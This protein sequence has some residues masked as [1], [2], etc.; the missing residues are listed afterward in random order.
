MEIEYGTSLIYKMIHSGRKPTALM[1]EVVIESEVKQDL[2]DGVVSKS[3][4]PSTRV[5]SHRRGSRHFIP[6]VNPNL[7]AFV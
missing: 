6:G 2:T 3:V 1:D 7:R 4:P 5:S